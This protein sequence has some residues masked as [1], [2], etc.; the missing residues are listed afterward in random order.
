MKAEKE[1]GIPISCRT[2]AVI[3]VESQRPANRL[4][5]MQCEELF[6]SMCN[7]LAR[8]YPEIHQKIFGK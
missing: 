4:H 1:A 2:G 5:S 8:D 7:E 6:E 3:S